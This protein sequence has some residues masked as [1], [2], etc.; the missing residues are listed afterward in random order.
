MF[1]Y[2]MTFTTIKTNKKFRVVVN[3]RLTHDCSMIARVE[4]RGLLTV[5]SLSLSDSI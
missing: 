2:Y 4:T 3:H 1:Y 5:W